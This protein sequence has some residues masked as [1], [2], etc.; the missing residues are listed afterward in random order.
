MNLALLSLVIVV[1]FEPTL[2]QQ[3]S[4]YSSQLVPTFAHVARIADMNND[5][6]NDAVVGTLYYLFVYFQTNDGTLSKP[7]VYRC[8]SV[9]S[10]DIA[11]FNNDNLPDVAVAVQTSGEEPHEA[12]SMK[13][14]F[15]GP[16]GTLQPGDIFYTGPGTRHL[17]IGDLNNDGLVD[18]IT[19]HM[20]D[21]NL[22]VFYQK[23]YGHFDSSVTY[24][25]FRNQTIQGIA[26]IGDFNGDGLND[27]VQNTSLA[28]Y[29]GGASV[30]LQQPNGSLQY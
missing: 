30:F 1:I 28:H 15:Q 4:P 16:N 12:D 5:G 20:D 27:V 18:I 23:P 24:P 26:E 6:R 29:G 13:I 19:T 8:G 9:R 7:K 22:R 25:S 3:F 10:I 17:S 21:N 14:F 11:D 2:A